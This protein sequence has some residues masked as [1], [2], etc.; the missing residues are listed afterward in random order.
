MAQILSNRDHNH[1]LEFVTLNWKI[2]PLNAIVQWKFY[3]QYIFLSF[4]TFINLLQKM[5]NSELETL[6]ENIFFCRLIT[7][8]IQKVCCYFLLNKNFLK[9]CAQVQLFFHRPHKES[10][11]SYNKNDTTIDNDKVNKRLF[12]KMINFTNGFILFIKNLNY[13]FQYLLKLT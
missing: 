2:C 11:K 4:S 12:L 9:T 3:Q 7:F 10:S 8:F 13:L 1:A 6:I 5:C